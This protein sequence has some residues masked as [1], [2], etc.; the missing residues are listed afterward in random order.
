M[1]DVNLLPFLIRG[2]PKILITFLVIGIL[3]CGPPAFAVDISDVPLDLQIN[4][5]AP[6]IMLVWDNSGSMNGEFMTVEP[7]GM[8]DHKK[9]LFADDAYVPSPDHAEGLQAALDINERLM[10]RSQWDGYNRLY[11]DPHRMYLPWPSTASYVFNPADTQFPWSD[12]TRTTAADA[13]FRLSAPFFTTT[14]GPQTIVIPNAHYFVL[15]DANGNGEQDAGESIYL[16]AWQDADGDQRLDLGK[17]VADDRRRF[18]RFNDDGDGLVEKDELQPVLDASEKNALKPACFDRRTGMARP[19]SDRQDLQNFAN[20]FTY[21]RRREYVAKAAAARIITGLRRAD[22]GIYAVNGNP[23][24]GVQPVEAAEDGDSDAL[25][26][27]GRTSDAGETLLDALYASRCGGKAPLRQALDQVGRYFDQGISSPLGSS[28]Y[29]AAGQGGGCQSAHAVIISDGFWNGAF[30]G[31][32]NA[33]GDQGTPYADA[34]E[35]T[36]ADVAMHYY[37][38]DLASDLA[39]RV[40]A[41]TCDETNHQ[42]MRTHALSL[43]VHGTVQGVNFKADGSTS[44]LCFAFTDGPPPEWPRPEAGQRSMQDD[45]LH[46]ALNGRGIFF[47]ADDPAA[48]IAA[49]N[50]DSGTDNES[51]S[52]AGPAVNGPKLDDGSI[53]Y[54]ARYRPGE[55]TG[56]VLAFAYHANGAGGADINAG[57]G[58]VLWRAAGW[59]LPADGVSDARRI[60][61]YGGPWREPQGVPFRYDQLSSEQKRALG[62]DL[63]AGSPSDRNACELLDYIRGH[64][65]PRYRKRTSL[66]GDIVHSAPVV[67]GGTLFVGSNDGMLHAFDAHTGRER[68]AFVPNLIM[69]QLKML[70]RPDYA[71]HHLFYVDAT[72]YVGEV[73]EGRYRRKTYLVGGL[74]KGGKGYYCLFLR[75]RRRE[76]TEKGWGSY[77]TLFSVDDFGAGTS[78]T[79]ISRI[80]RWEYPPLRIDDDSIDNDGDG[81]VDEPDESDPDIGYS[82]GQGYA[83]NANAPDG[84]YRPVVIFGNGYNSRS[85]KAVLYIVDIA[86]GKLIRKIDT[87]AGDDNGLSVPALIDVNLDRCIDY[88]Y[89]GDL[90]GNLWKFDLRANR[91]DQWGVAYGEDFD[92]D[93]VIDA[94]QGDRPQPVFQAGP[95]QPITG[96]PDIMAMAGACAPQ[97]PGYMVIFGTGRYLGASDRNDTHRQSIYGIWDFGDDGDDSEFLGHLTNRST[98]S[99]SSGL[100]LQPRRI[101]DQFTRDGAVYR[102]LS[103]WQADYP[104]IEDDRDRDGMAVNNKDRSQQADPARLAGWFLDFPVPPEPWALPGERV[105]GYVVIRNGQAVIISYAPADQPCEKGGFSWIYALGACGDDGPSKKRTDSPMMPKRFESRISDNMIVVKNAAYP[106]MDTLLCSDLAG[107]IIQEQLSGEKVG[108]VF[109]R[110]GQ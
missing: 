81:R 55:W 26:G 71:D 93:G 90:K 110:Q 19:L 86:T 108:K 67:D 107:R 6:A 103:P 22:V 28:P 12:P 47:P 96:R 51:V 14:T 102:Q 80:V 23:R 83:V 89:A 49:L 97:A 92:R 73:L 70:G 91:P 36:L 77:E 99:L 20:W 95:Q 25:S 43:G 32:G 37:N 59:L 15:N 4:A 72:P 9:Y 84:T 58:N 3:L 21:Y 57:S 54:Q 94:S 33:D 7:E 50:N 44:D 104:T 63:T 48:L 109:W 64:E 27:A 101:I 45:L 42:H 41:Q 24:I 18:F 79:D 65:Y 61:T 29:K 11:Y 34:W 75:D 17:T 76:K 106:T 10:W 62:S 13:R 66:L 100:F 52:A 69:D 82:F 74:G 30:S 88:A 16:V 35:D 31:V 2:W 5:P 8:F 38:K 105:T 98:G 68:F 60:V 39:D 85:G 78:E 1:S 53:I 46:A 56:D 87:G 40:P